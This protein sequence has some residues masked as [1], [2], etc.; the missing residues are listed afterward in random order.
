MKSLQLGLIGECMIELQEIE[1]GVI[2]QTF[3]GDTLNT[4]I[5][6]ARL[7]A[8]LPM[9]VEYITA[10]GADSFSGRMIQ[11]WE[12]EGVGSALVQRIAGEMPGLYYIET[13][14]RGERIFHYWRSTAA[15]K[16][17][18]EYPESKALLEQLAKYNAI[19]LSGISLAIFTPQSRKILITRLKELAS[20]GV[21]IYFDCNY[22]PRLWKSIE[23]AK[24]VY[25]EVYALSEIVFLT[26]EEAA[27][28]LDGGQGAEV[29]SILRQKG[30]RE[31]VLKDGANPCTIFI[32]DSEQ[33][34]PAGTVTQVVDTTAAGDSFGGV[35]LTARYFGCP[36]GEAARMAHATA[37]Y[38]VSHKGAVVPRE[39][40]PVTGKD[41]C[42]CTKQDN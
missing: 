30:A 2:R 24:S 36:P 28:L 7:S 11:F 32:H 35:Y 27:D 37:A 9:T 17:C 25:A 23:E 34:V 12:K 33:Q 41:I 14:E 31:I 42:S 1:P 5:Y 21:R 16:K 20:Q 38:V 8:E 4:A 18:F 15:A 6:C 22:R 13:D 26:T 39:G 10:V 3:G 19:Y 40:I 29:G